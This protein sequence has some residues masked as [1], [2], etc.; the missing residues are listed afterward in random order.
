MAALARI[1]HPARLS[2][3]LDYAVGNV[4]L[5]RGD[6]RRAQ[7]ILG[8]ALHTAETSHDELRFAATLVDIA[9]IEL[10]RMNAADAAPDLERALA[11]EERLLGPDHPDLAKLHVA[12]GGA[13]YE[14]DD[15]DGAVGHDNAQV[16]NALDNLALARQWQNRVD[17]ALA[18][19]R[20][21]IAIDEKVLPANDPDTAA[22][23]ITEAN[24]LEQ[25]RRPADALPIIDRALAML[26]TL[27]GSEHQDIA[28]ALQTRAN[29][30][31]RAGHL[32]T[33]LADARTSLAMFDK[34]NP[35]YPT[36]ELRVSL[37]RIQLAL[38]H[39]VDALAELEGARTHRRPGNDPF[40]AHVLDGL[41]G[42]ALVETNRD[43]A[44]GIVLVTSA[45]T[46]LRADKRAANE[47]G[48][49]ES[50]MRQ[51]HLTLPP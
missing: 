35:T 37:G 17:D 42:I 23:L 6:L 30:N 5:V 43:R 21:A 48:D 33:A 22:H 16:A 20:E 26:R 45:Y 13:A 28:D 40:D 2:A 41:Y 47:V 14:R 4:A 49:L 46:A 7:G 51:A 34:V 1:G 38:H 3:D 9:Q 31:F 8:N 15:Y 18:E 29:I 12:L 50:F 27:Y 36:E 11:I 25:L 24:L 32:D 10:R 44:R 39:P 19:I